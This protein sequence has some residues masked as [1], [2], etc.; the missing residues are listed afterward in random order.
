MLFISQLFARC[1]HHIQFI[2]ATPA[3]S[4]IFSF[5]R[6]MLAASFAAPC[7][8]PPLRYADSFRRLIF[9]SMMP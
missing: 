3:I 1:R 8:L 9:F 7:R 4:D 2:A 5:C 6:L